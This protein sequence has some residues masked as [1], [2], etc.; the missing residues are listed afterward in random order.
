MLKINNIHKK[1]G[2]R[3][4]L[5]QINL[6]L[7]GGE[8]AAIL[9]PN[10]SGKT[11]LMRIIAG[12]EKPDQGSVQF[13]PST[14]KWHAMPQDRRFPEGTRLR[15]VLQQE[16]RDPAELEATLE[17]LSRRLS[18]APQDEALQEAFDR[19]LSAL[20]SHERDQ[21]AVLKI[22]PVFALEAFTLDTPVAIL[23]GGQRARLCLAAAVLSGAQL[24]LLDEPTN[25]LDEPMLEWLENWFLTFTGAI[26]FVSHDRAFLNRTATEILELDP[27][28]HTLTLYPGNYDDWLER[29][30]AERGAA[31]AAWTRQQSEIG[32]LRDAVQQLRA[33]AKFRRGGKADSG[34][35]FMTGFFANRSKG[36]VKRATK[37]EERLDKIRTDEKLEKPGRHWKMKMDFLPVNETGMRVLELRDLTVGYDDAALISDIDLSLWKGQKCVLAGPNGSGKTTLIRTIMGELPPL[38]GAVRF[39]ANVHPGLMSQGLQAA[40]FTK[41][42]F[43]TIQAVSALNETE[44]RRFLSYYLF[45]DDEVFIPSEVLS[46][47]QAARLMLAEMAVR[48]VNFLIMD[49]PLNHLDIASREQFGDAVINFPG[50]VLAVVH[51]RYFM[52]RFA[53]VIWRVDHGRIRIQ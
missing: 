39:G 31:L 16:E 23:S 20:T 14:L 45:F 19:T 11:T 25:D 5:S 53:E 12:Q 2:T 6:S 17:I 27:H 7:T 51:D 48:G 33:N 15:D 28:T 40:Q 49:E 26:L 21:D 38:A 13:T 37:I 30:N 52:D 41:N 22:L 1:Y 35:K 32:A 3:Q 42:A 47:G 43:E 34:D 24:L 8:R 29:K 9:G 50:A 36:T 4:V 46:N 44:I 10:G 18:V